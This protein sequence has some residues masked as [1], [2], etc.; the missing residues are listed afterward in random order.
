MPSESNPGAAETMIP[1]RDALMWPN[2]KVSDGSQ[3][4]TAS[5]SPHGVSAGARSLDRH[6]WEFSHVKR[7]CDERVSPVLCTT[8]INEGRALDQRIE[9]VGSLVLQNMG[10]VDT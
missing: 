1:V 4:P 6:G 7:E 2:A 9:Y 3:P 8:P 10:V 5:A